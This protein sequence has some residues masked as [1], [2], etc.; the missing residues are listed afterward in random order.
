MKQEQIN[1]IFR[2]ALVVSLVFSGGCAAAMSAPA[3]AE[4]V[5]PAMV[6][7]LATIEGMRA[8]FNGAQG[9]FMMQ[10][11][12]AVIFAWP[13]GGS[14]S[15]SIVGAGE[16]ALKGMRTATVSFSQMVKF[17]ESTGWSYIDKSA[18]PT[19]IAQALMAYTAEMALTAMQSLP[20]VLIVP[21]MLLPTPIPDTQL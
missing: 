10:N 16:Q 4:S 13:N 12:Q 5:S 1:R 18:V 3:V 7:P 2:L 8:A 14:W 15:F 21:A 17:L 19:A 20:T 9:T 11:G 6:S